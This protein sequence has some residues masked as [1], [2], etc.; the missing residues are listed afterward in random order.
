[1]D[2]EKI[3][4]Q[5]KRKQQEQVCGDLHRPDLGTGWV[6]YSQGTGQVLEQHENRRGTVVGL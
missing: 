3:A 4:S 1:M 6:P 2:K 5:E